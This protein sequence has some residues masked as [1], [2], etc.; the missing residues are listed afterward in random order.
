VS[1]DVPALTSVSWFYNWTFTVSGQVATAIGPAAMEFVPMVWGKNIN[2][3]NIANAIPAG[4]KYLL[5]FNEPN[6]GAQ[7]NLTPTQAAQLWPLIEQIAQ[8]KNLKI[9]SPAVNVCGPPATCNV[10]DPVA[11]M[12]QFLAACSG[13]KIDHMAIHW[14]A[15]TSQALQTYVAR[16]KKYNKPLWVTEFDCADQGTVSVDVQ[17]AYLRDALSYLEAE[18]AVFR[19]SWFSGRTTQVANVDLLA[20]AGQLTALGQDYVSAAPGTSCQR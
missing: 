15:C 18:P 10:Q 17:R 6:F 7:S 4:A 1:A 14:Y 20:A 13:C 12:D 19:Y 8:R 3:D 16:F 11:W 9:V 5:G 2:V